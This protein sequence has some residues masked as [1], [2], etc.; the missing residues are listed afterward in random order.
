MLATTNLNGGGELHLID[1]TGIIKCRAY[2]IGKHSYQL[3]ERL[4]KEQFSTLSVKEG[5][6]LL[7]DILRECCGG[8]E[9]KDNVASSRKTLMVEDEEDDAHDV[10][11]VP[12]GS[13][14]EI[15][16]LDANERNLRR[17]RQP[18]L[19]VHVALSNNNT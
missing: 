13:C 2:A 10:W 6:Q 1:T 18:L 7:L 12:P 8:T 4:A 5:A 3:N 9:N 15:A 17:I 19:K 11:V 16:M 14:V